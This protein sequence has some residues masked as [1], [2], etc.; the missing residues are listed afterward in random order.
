MQKNSLPSFTL[1]LDLKKTN[2]KDQKKNKSS[3]IH[4]YRKTKNFSPYILILQV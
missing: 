1:A 4:S 3:L 2:T